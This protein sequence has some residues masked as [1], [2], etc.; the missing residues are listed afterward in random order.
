MYDLDY[1]HKNTRQGMWLLGHKQCSRSP[2]ML[3]IALVI[4]RAGASPPSRATGA[5]FLYIYISVRRVP[6]YRIYTILLQCYAHAHIHLSHV[7]VP[8]SRLQYIPTLESCRERIVCVR[9]ERRT[10]EGRLIASS[11]VARS[12]HFFAASIINS[13]NARSLSIN[14]HRCAWTV[15]TPAD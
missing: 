4:G 11:K 6:R 14:D 13:A 2:K 3:S 8:S 9:W 15:S 10:R 7:F 12:P 1:C 5:I